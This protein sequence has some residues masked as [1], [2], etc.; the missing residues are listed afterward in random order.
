M[1]PNLEA[2]INKTLEKHFDGSK[3]SR[4]PCLRG[5]ANGNTVMI[6]SEALR[7]EKALHETLNYEEE[8]C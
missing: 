5:F 7:P 3:V 6:A 1:F 2:E 8:E 4:L